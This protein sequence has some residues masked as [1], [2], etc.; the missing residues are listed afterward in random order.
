AGPW[1]RVVSSW[2]T[3]RG[4][5]SPHLVRRPRAETR[6]RLHAAVLRRRDALLARRASAMGTMPARD[7]L[8][9]AHARRDVRAVGRARAGTRHVRVER[10]ARSRALPRSRVGRGPVGRAQARAARERR[11]D[12]LRISRL[13]AG[14][15][16][17]SGAHRARFAR[18]DAGTAAGVSDSVVRV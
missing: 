5:T 16:A 9:R 17:V 2:R 6:E 18:M 12:E 8:A 10:A 15:S 11:A 14:R 1:V 13:G 4:S 7:A 3:A